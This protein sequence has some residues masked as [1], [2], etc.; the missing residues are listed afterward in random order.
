[1]ALHDFAEIVLIG[2]AIGL[3]YIVWHLLAKGAREIRPDLWSG[4]IL[5]LAAVFPIAYVIIQKSILYNA[6]RHVT[7]VLPPLA[8]LAAW[9]G[10]SMFASLNGTGKKLATISV[11]AYLSFHV[12]TMVRLHPD[13]YVYFNQFVGGL[14]G[15]NGLYET[16]YWGNSYREAVHDLT[17]YVQT[18]GTPSPGRQIQGLHRVCFSRLHLVLL[19]EK[20]LA[21]HRAHRGGLL[22]RQHELPRRQKC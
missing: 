10:Y 11:L 3:I 14:K 22:H 6:E 16:D 8:C 4:A 9:G 15:A 12:V 13:E 2:L 17:H 1:M 5:L 21:N 19:A 20:L 7:F 18:S